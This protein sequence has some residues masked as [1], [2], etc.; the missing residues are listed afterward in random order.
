MKK[1]YESIMMSLGWGFVLQC[2]SPSGFLL[3]SLLRLRI[4]LFATIAFYI[5][6]VVAIYLLKKKLS[7]N[8]YKEYV[9][10]EQREEI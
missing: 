4:Y 7:K 3:D 6:T 5:A 10:R 8:P 2:I 1:A 9:P